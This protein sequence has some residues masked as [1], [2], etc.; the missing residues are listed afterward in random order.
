MAS[1]AQIIV[2]YARLATE[3]RNNQLATQN[4]ENKVIQL[5]QAQNTRPQRSLPGETEPN[6][7]QLME[8]TLRSGR[9][10]KDAPKK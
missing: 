8:I 4:L 7:K 5:A 10:L 9:D 3:V 1:Q 6:P 2:E